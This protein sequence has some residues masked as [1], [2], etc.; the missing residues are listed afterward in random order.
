LIG[1]RDDYENNGEVDGD[2]KEKDNEDR[3]GALERI[4]KLKRN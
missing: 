2:A 1:K 3:F 4:K